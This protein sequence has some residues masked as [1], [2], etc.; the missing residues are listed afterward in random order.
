MKTLKLSLLFLLIGSL[1]MLS[2]CNKE[3]CKKDDNIIS[4]NGLELS[5]G[6]EVPPTTSKAYGT[7][8]VSYDKSTRMLTY[9]IT[10]ASLTGIPTGSHIHGTAKRGV[11]APIKHD[12][13]ALF[14]KTISGTF[15]NA[16]WVDGVAIT[17]D[18]LLNGFYYLNIHTPTN[19]G[20]EIRG[21]IEFK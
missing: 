3:K 6:Q 16:V 8:N 15:K 17:E 9:D 14:P 10:W 19:P 12:F 11:N 5:T 1:I 2:S 21:Q 18:S 20:G 13:F 7:M 4:K